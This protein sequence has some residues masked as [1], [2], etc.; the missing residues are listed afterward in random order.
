MQ[1]FL[2]NLKPIGIIGVILGIGGVIGTVFWGLQIVCQI[3]FYLGVLLLVLPRIIDLIFKKRSVKGVAIVFLLF[4]LINGLN[5]FE[6]LPS[7]FFKGTLLI[8]SEYLFYSI[9]QIFRFIGSLWLFLESIFLYKNYQKYNFED[10]LKTT[11]I[12]LLLIF[13]GLLI[14]LEVPIFGWHYGFFG[15]FKHG[16]NF[17]NHGFHLH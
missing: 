5:Q 15:D 17:W 1:W 13:I 16:H 9:M 3:L 2:S 12:R 14:F 7:I 8:K 11:R 6:F 4:S 10:L